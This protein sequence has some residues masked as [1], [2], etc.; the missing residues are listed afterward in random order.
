MEENNKKIYHVDVRETLIRS[1]KVEASS[2]QEAKEIA[3]KMY[4]EEEIV[5]DSEDF[6]GETDC[7]VLD[8]EYNVLEDWEIDGINELR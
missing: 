8:E 5:L 3:A 2:I 1:V 6:T 7:R 4:D